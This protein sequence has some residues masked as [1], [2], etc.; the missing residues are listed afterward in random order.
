[1]QSPLLSISYAYDRQQVIYIF[2]KMRV[3]VNTQRLYV[4][5]VIHR[6]FRRLNSY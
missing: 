1:M 4:S 5:N 2:D 3:K 6:D